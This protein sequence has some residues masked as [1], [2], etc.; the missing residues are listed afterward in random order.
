MA[1]T[2]WKKF[3]EAVA[4]EEDDIT[5]GG[6]DGTDGLSTTPHLPPSKFITSVSEQRAAKQNS[7]LPPSR[8]RNSFNGTKTPV[9]SAFQPSYD[10][11]SPDW[12]DDITFKNPASAEA[13]FG[14]GSGEGSL[15][16]SKKRKQEEIEVPYS[17][18]TADEDA[19]TESDP[20]EREE[21]IVSTRWSKIRCSTLLINVNIRISSK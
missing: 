3:L 12:R 20:D 13:N 10:F 8:V 17:F 7:T 16:K 21:E 6:M 5:M 11:A 1:R 2:K 15:R 19:P 4:E 9:Q 14:T 18:T